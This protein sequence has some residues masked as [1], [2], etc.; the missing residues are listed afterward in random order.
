MCRT[1]IVDGVC[2]K[3][4]RGLCGSRRSRGFTLIEL[5]VVIAIIAILAAILFPVF[6]KAKEA[7]RCTTCVS[8]MRQIADAVLMY[9]DNSNGRLPNCK[10]H[11]RIWWIL[12]QG[13]STT[14]PGTNA[15]PYL[16]DLV[17]RKYIKNQAVWLCPSMNK[18]QFWSQNPNALTGA[19]DISQYHVYENCGIV[20]PGGAASVNGYAPT[21]YRWTHVRARPDYFQTGPQQLPVSGTLASAMR[22][23]S[24]VVILVEFPYWNGA[25]HSIVDSRTGSYSSAVN[26]AFYDGH[27]KLRKMIHDNEGYACT[28]E[29]W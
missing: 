7:A 23:S 13:G 24:K 12:E 6:T 10:Y 22:Q 16:Q 15:G 27:V 17:G 14:D 20:P 9:T 2:K 26:V 19:K 18:S 8:N 25:P 4:T 11:G 1:L 29:G 21:N 28:K 5:L 3:M